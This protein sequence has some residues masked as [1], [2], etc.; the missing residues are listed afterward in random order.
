MQQKA[1]ALGSSFPCVTLDT[2]APIPGHPWFSF[3]T[4]IGLLGASVDAG[5]AVSHSPP[6][7]L[8]WPLSRLPQDA[9]EHLLPGRGL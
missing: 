7:S 8:P 2:E 4:N 6:M 3:L 1:E 9:Q 5:E